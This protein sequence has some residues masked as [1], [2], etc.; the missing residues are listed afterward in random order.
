MDVPLKDQYTKGGEESRCSSPLSTARGPSYSCLFL[1]T[2]YDRFL[3]DLYQAHPHLHS[4]PFETQ[5]LEV[6]RTNN[7][8]S[9]FYSAG[10]RACGWSAHQIVINSP[11][12]QAAWAREHGVS[13]SGEALIV[14]QAARMKCDVI[15]CQD[16]HG[17][18]EPL[19]RELKRHCKLLVGQIASTS[20]HVPL[21]CYDVVVSSILPLVEYCRRIGISSFHVPLAFHP[22]VKEGLSLPATFSQRPIGCSF[23]GSISSDVHKSRVE[24]L[25]YLA[26]RVPLEIWGAGIE[27]L[28]ADSPLRGC[29]R[30]PAWGPQLFSVLG[31]SRMTVNCHAEVLYN[32]EQPTNS[33][34][35]F[36]NNM[37]LFEATG[38]GALLLTEYRQ[39]LGDLFELGREIVV[40]RG[41]D[42]CEALIKY[43]L[44]HPEEAQEIAHAGQMRTLRDHSYQQR[45]ETL[46]KYL[47]NLIRLQQRPAQ[48]IDYQRIS[49]DFKSVAADDVTTQHTEA[50][51]S[52]ELPN[53]Q[54]AL[55][56][57]ELKEM[58][59][60]ARV[61]PFRSLQEVL[62]R[63]LHA[64]DSLLEIGCSSGYYSEVISYLVPK[65]C[66]YTGV[67][68]SEPM[69][70]MAKE[71]YPQT[72]FAVASGDDLP[73]QD[74]SFDVVI[75]GGVLLHCPNYAEHI[76]ETA[77]VTKRALLLTRTPIC[78]RQPT[79]FFTKKAYGVE[80]VE[81]IFNEAEIV[82]AVKQQGFVLTHYLVLEADDTHDNYTVTYAF[83]RSDS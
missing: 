22:R 61:L 63:V 68:Y 43:Y 82:E 54:R 18:S 62:S 25:T 71:L 24:F 19:L 75:S 65:R 8:D 30:G 47:S 41:F 35:D 4:A 56:D 66:T 9:D 16:M 46:S 29:Y 1:D 38:M 33:T 27:R 3:S 20:L 78:R 17:L 48:T 34:K 12:M 13:L 77:R 57:H 28:P 44:K 70:R 73:F 76:V 79:R 58:Y 60:G 21:H 10:L 50:W 51:K 2:F 45:M 11:T 32:K 40:Y 49:Y 31:N 72:S 5:L 81:L 15:Y 39:N 69:I 80:T 6:I 37:R 64:G 83:M 52:G 26:Q 67:D 7:G 53:K 59:R 36:A 42:E 74:R 23:V 55:V 14:E